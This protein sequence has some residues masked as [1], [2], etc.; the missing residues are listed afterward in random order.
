LSLVF[1][2][3]LFDTHVNMFIVILSFFIEIIDLLLFLLFS[4][5]GV[6]WLCFCCWQSLGHLLTKTPY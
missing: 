6:V 4:I 2:T 3:C 5:L 1:L